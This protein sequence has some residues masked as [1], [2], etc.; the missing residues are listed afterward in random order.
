MISASSSHQAQPPY[1]FDSSSLI[2][3]ERSNTLPRIPVEPRYVI[4]PQRVYT[5]VNK[6]RALIATW[7]RRNS[8][9]SA[10]FQTPAEGSL[11]LELRRQHPGLGDGEASAIAI[12]HHRNGTVVTEDRLARRVADTTETRWIGLEQ[13]FQGVV[14]RMF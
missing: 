11:Y 5:E 7:L 13:Y 8:L 2:D 6:P 9:R 3:L 14:P 1:I 10:Q 12:A 4:I